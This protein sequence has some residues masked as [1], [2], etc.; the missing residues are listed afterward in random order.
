MSKAVDLMGQRFGRLTVI[1]KQGSREYRPGRYRVY[2]RCKC[3]CGNECSAHT[4]DLRIGKVKSCGCL[5]KEVLDTIGERTRSQNRFRIDGKIVHVFFNNKPAE[6]LVDLDVWNAW[7][8]T[9]CWNLNANGYAATGYNGKHTLFHNIAFPNRIKGIVIDHINGNRLDNRLK[10]L[11]LVNRQQN[12]MN[13]GMRSDNTSGHIG[14]SWSKSKKK[15]VAQIQISGV[16]KTLGR[17]DK[18]E[19]AVKARKEAEE[20]YFGEYRR[21]E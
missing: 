21:K 12:V 1:E 6:M 10:N 11:R 8:S 7:A 14:V 5:R 3:D 18:I 20:K 4:T 19:D 13:S 15:W 9:Y 16:N 2:W 17:Y